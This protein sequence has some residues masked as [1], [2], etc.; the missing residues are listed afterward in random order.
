MIE[1]GQISQLNPK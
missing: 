1:N